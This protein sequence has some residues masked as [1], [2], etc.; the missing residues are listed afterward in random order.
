MNITQEAYVESVMQYV[1]RGW[2]PFPVL[3]NEKR[4]A[5]T[6]YKEKYGHIE[7]TEDQVK[8]WYE[9][10]YNVGI[11][12]EASDLVLVD[13][14]SYKEKLPDDFALPSTGLQATTPSGGEHYIYRAGEDFK[15]AQFTDAQ[16]PIG[17]DIKYHGYGLAAPSEINGKCYQWTDFGEPTVITLEQINKW[18]SPKE[19]AAI[20]ISEED[21]DD[22]IGLLANVVRNGF[23]SGRHNEQLRDIARLMTRIVH[24]ETS[25]TLKITLI[26]ALLNALDARDATPQGQQ[27]LLQTMSSAMKYELNRLGSPLSTKA[28]SPD[29]GMLE[30]TKAFARPLSVVAGPYMNYEI[31]WLIDGWL[32]EK[33]VIMMAAPPETYKTWMLLDMAV[34]MSLGDKG[35]LF[36]DTYAVK[37]E[38]APVMIVQQ[39]DFTGDILNRIQR[40]MNARGAK[41]TWSI[42]ETEHG[43]IIDSPMSAPI[44]MHDQYSLSFKDP[45]SFVNMETTIKEHGIKQVFIDP[46]Y[47]ITKKTDD[48]FAGEATEFTVLKKIRDRTGCGFLLC[49]HTKKSGSANERGS[50]WGSVLLNGATEGAIMVSPDKKSGDNHINLS[51]SGKKFPDVKR[52]KVSFDIEGSGYRCEVEEI[53]QFNKDSLE[54]DVVDLI[55]AANAGVIRQ[56]DLINTGLI[57]KTNRSKAKRTLDSMVD[58]GILDRNDDDKTYSLAQGEQEETD[59]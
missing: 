50:I 48:Y 42:T 57:P 53:D 18:A 3:S 4:P 26:G 21:K 9:R 33:S 37:P 13:V 49:H 20:Q 19:V 31:E 23:E 11:L 45:G 35:Y 27:Q 55:M 41:T 28:T 10:G 59:E 32:P 39:E 22:A 15:E 6:G 36:L 17:V 34:S 29:E 52:A 51:R 54:S 16:L 14:D 2:K 12:M 30:P 24:P 5:E 25:Q 44:Y 58:S 7:L 56:A 47:S 8:A 1:E 38:R 40:I 43:V 46:F